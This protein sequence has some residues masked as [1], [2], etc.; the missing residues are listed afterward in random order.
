MTPSTTVLTSQSTTAA[1]STT[2]STTT[3]P[4][5]SVNYSSNQHDSK[6]NYTDN[7]AN[8]NHCNQHDSKHNC[9]DQSVNYSS[10]Q[11]DSKLNCP[12]NSHNYTDNSANYNHCNQHD[13]KHN[14]PDQ[15][16][17]YS[18]NQHDSKHNYP[19]NS[20]NYHQC[21]QRPSRINYCGQRCRII[22]HLSGHQNCQT[23]GV[24]LTGIVSRAFI[25]VKM[26]SVGGLSDDIILQAVQQFL[27]KQLNG[28]TVTASVTK[29]ERVAAMS[30]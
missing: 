6:H 10:N 21:H 7:S 3:L 12:D 11:H 23:I 29:V 5:N 24:L 4:D 16:V 22:N 28:T 2:P 8:Y 13:S 20:S 18:S 17:N 15:S 1:T 27:N 25:Q 19:D 26:S 30:R 14:C 9:P